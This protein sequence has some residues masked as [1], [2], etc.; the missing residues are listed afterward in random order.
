MESDLGRFSPSGGR[1]AADQFVKMFLANRV[2]IVLSVASRLDDA[3]H[4]HE[5]QVM[6]HGWLGLPQPLA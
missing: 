3:G 6:T 2:V 1:E 4:P 5:R